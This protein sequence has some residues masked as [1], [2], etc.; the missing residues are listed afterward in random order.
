MQVLEPKP[1][2]R[3]TRALAGIV[4]LEEAAGVYRR[5]GSWATDPDDCMGLAS[6][7]L[8]E[9]VGQ[10]MGDRQVVVIE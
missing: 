7:P 8:F 3:Q 4:L 9:F 2:R 5:V 10:H 1:S 6:E